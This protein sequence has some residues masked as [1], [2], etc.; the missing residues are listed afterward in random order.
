VRIFW[1]KADMDESDQLA[2]FKK[3]IN[4]KMKLRKKAKYEIESYYKMFDLRREQIRALK[5]I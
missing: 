2:T 4:N 1:E 3:R 5:I